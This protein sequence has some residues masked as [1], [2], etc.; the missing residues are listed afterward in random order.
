MNVSQPTL[1]RPYVVEIHQLIGKAMFNQPDG[2]V[3]D[4]VQNWLWIRKEEQVG[5][6]VRDPRDLRL[7]F[8]DVERQVGRQREV[9]LHQTAVASSATQ[10]RIGILEL[11]QGVQVHVGEPQ[12][13]ENLATGVVQTEHVQ[14]GR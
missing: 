5:I 12:G 10:L 3:L 7:R 9:V 11:L 13:G 8:E 4:L 1:N 2:A 14:N 6:D